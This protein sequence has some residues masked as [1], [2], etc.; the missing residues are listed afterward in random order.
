[1]SAHP[2]HIPPVDAGETAVVVLL[3]EVD[4]RIRRWHIRTQPV[5]LPAHITLAYPFKPIEDVTE[6]DLELLRSVFAS[7]TSHVITLARTGRFPGVL[8]LEPEDDARFRR[9]TDEI[10]EL[11]PEYP[12]YG[13]AFEDVIPH[14]TVNHGLPEHELDVVEHELASH[15]PMQAF[16]HEGWLMTFDGEEW[17]TEARFAFRE[18]H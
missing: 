6:H 18:P 3:H 11:W 7:E 4:E 2:S 5:G 10:T 1:M 16:A 13:G 17:S 9:L 12:P 14:V 15:L 8:Y